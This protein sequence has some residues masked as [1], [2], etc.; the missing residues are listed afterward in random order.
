M[1]V[2][3]GMVGGV[4][5]LAVFAAFLHYEY[6]RA[7]DPGPE[8]IEYGKRGTA[9]IFDGDTLDLEGVRIR[10]AGIDACELDQVAKLVT[11]TWPC[12]TLAKARLV[13]LTAG[14]DI[15]CIWSEL[16][17]YD[18]ALA[19]CD[20]YGTDLVLNK[21]MVQEGLAV[22]YRGSG[23]GT[24][25][26]PSYEE[27]EALA[28]QNRRGLWKTEFEVPSEHRRKRSPQRP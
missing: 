14:A 23:E 17:L 19:I 11:E 5:L 22:G 24:V 9:Q 16:D 2:F 25:S 1:K 21:I 4:I 15:R 7:F 20:I 28:K 18:R 26:N 6:R 27:I 3:F 13:E 12:G 8:A 10:L